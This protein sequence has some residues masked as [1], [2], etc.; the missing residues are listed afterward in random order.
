MYRLTRH[1]KTHYCKEGHI[2]CMPK[3]DN[4]LYPRLTTDKKKV[5]CRKCL[6]I[7]NTWIKPELLEA[8]K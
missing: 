1:L 7:C 5:D 6:K 3:T 8:V 4:Y 2:L